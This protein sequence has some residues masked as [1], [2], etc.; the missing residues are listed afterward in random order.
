M[1]HARAKEADGVSDV[2]RWG[3]GQRG[4][5]NYV[6]GSHAGAGSERS[7]V[8]AVTSLTI[9]P[10]EA[11]ATGGYPREATGERRLIGQQ[12]GSDAVE[13]GELCLEELIP[14]DE[15]LAKTDAPFRH[16]DL[17]EMVDEGKP[18]LVAR[19]FRLDRRIDGC[20]CGVIHA[21][22]LA[23]ATARCTYKR[24]CKDTEDGDGDSGHDPADVK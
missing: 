18:G 22:A 4:I 6:R 23:V 1:H 24:A 7:V 20:G 8:A 12:Q 19:R 16:R 9:R 3:A 13:S 11:T 15:E 5:L 17:V 14:D 10:R 2:E 21:R